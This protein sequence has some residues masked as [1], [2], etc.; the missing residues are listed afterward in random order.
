MNEQV[1]LKDIAVKSG[2]SLRTVKKVMSGDRSV[3]AETREHIL[4]IGKKLGYRKNMTARVLGM[5]K[6][7]NIAIV[8]GHS[9]YFFSEARE[10]FL[11]CWKSWRDLKVE[12]QFYAVKERT[13][14]AE[15][16][17]LR[18]LQGEE[19]IDAVLLHGNSMGKLDEEINGLV[20]SGKVVCTFGLDS[21]TSKRLFYVGP[22]AYGTGRIAAQTISS[23]IRR[24]K[25]LYIIH[26]AREIPENSRR[27]R[28]VL[29]YMQEKC[30]E[31]PIKLIEVTDGTQNYH[32][33]VEELMHRE[34]VAGIIGTNADC[35]IIGEEARKANRNDII[36]LGF[37]L[38]ESTEKLIKDGYFTVILD[39]ATQ[40][41]AFTALDCLCRH[42]LYQAK[43]ENI[44]TEILI[45][46]SE[47]L[48]YR[49][50]VDDDN[51]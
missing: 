14:Q 12:I 17:L 13:L 39:Q 4:D 32:Q 40:R 7:H 41:Q 48:R 49:E 3:R 50:H 1:T 5:N 18:E 24:D 35:Y 47:I 51:W 37:D 19:S 36:S 9:K 20:E 29:D 21:P 33:R 43:V 34:D 46:T 8:L 16:E 11:E 26:H 28:G 22:R 38:N 45:V 42:L 23:L 6:V 15:R 31:L 2:Y 10:G 30:P 27:I 44:Y 25:S